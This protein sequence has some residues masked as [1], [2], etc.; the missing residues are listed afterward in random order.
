[1]SDNL[2]FY[3]DDLLKKPNI[4]HGFYTRLGKH[5]DNTIFLDQVHGSK[6]LYVNVPWEND[7]RP[8][9]DGFVTDKIGITLGILTADCAPVLFSGAK[10]NGSP[11]IG[12]AHA[13]WQGALKGVLENT[14]QV[15]ENM[16][17]VSETINACVGP[18]IAKSSY[19]V[20][21]SFSGA[22]IE[23]DAQSKAFFVSTAN[24]G[25]LM[26]DLSGYCAWRLSRTNINNTTLIDIDTYRNENE[27]YSFRRSTHRSESNYGRQISVISISK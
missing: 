2:K 24:P 23:E 7:V 12:A 4:H 13:G 10:E 5:P 20:S 11:V 6:V 16:G 15:M 18:C 3:Q 1:M 21:E 26:F 25:H 8:K 14:V 17:A 9:A 22:F 27:F 19:E